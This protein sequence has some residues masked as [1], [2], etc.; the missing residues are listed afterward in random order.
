MSKW[1]RYLEFFR[2]N[3]ARDIDDEISSHLEM[4]IADLRARGLTEAAARSQALSEFGDREAA[5]RDALRVDQRMMRREARGE[6]LDGLLRD[7]RVAVRSLRANPGFAVSAILCAAAGIGITAA[8]VSA[9]YA[10]LVRSLPYRDSD[11]V[12]A[13]YAENVTRG[14]THTNISSPDFASWR[15]DNR[16]FSGIAIW[17]WGTKTLGAGAGSDAERLSGADVSWNLFRILGVAP[18]LGRDFLQEEDAPGRQFEVLISHQLWQR[19]F[20]SDSAIVGQ[21]IPI[22]GRAWTVVGVMPRGFNFP[23]VGDYW[24]PFAASPAER[25]GDRGY[26]G[27]IGRLAPGV[28]LA[29]AAADLHR[30]DAE[31]A[32]RFPDD[33]REWRAQLIPI[34][35]DLI[36]DLRAPLRVLLA[37]VGLVLLLACINIAGL[38]LA[39]GAAR[40]REIAIRTAVGA[41][42]ERLVRQLLTESVVIAGVGGIL[43]LGI[44]AAAM[45][46]LT[47][48]FPRGVPFYIHLE[49]DLSAVTFVCVITLLTGLLFGIVPALRGSRIELTAAL[50]DG[51]SGS[52]IGVDRAR[53][54]RGL[55]VAE[56]ALSAV[57]LTGAF[58]LL[59][60]YRNLHGMPLGY[61]P[62]GVVTAR[63]TLPKNAGYPT[64][65]DVK[66]FYDRLFER[67]RGDPRVAVVG[68]AQGTPMTGWDVQGSLDVDGG[69]PARAGDVLIVHYQYVTADYFRAIGV[70]LVRGRWLDATDRDSLHPSVLVNER[71]VAKAFNGAEPI[72]KRVR[73]GS[74][75]PWGTVVGVIGDFQQF[76]IP[77][78]IPPAVYWSDAS[79]PVRQKTVAIR[80]RTG[81]PR[82]LVPAL[83]SAVREIDPGVAVYQIQTMNEVLDRTL[84]R[85]SFMRKVLI[86]F[87]T[88]A[89]SMACLGLYGVLSYTVA[90]RTRE[91]GVR[92]ALGASRVRLLRMVL[93]DGARLALTGIAAGLVT[94]WFAARF[95]AA[96]LYGVEANDPMVFAG[97]AGALIAVALLAMMIPSRR[98]TRVDPLVAMRAE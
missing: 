90:Q 87:A 88:L 45:R 1:L 89:I 77:E 71:L 10:I 79:Y 58:L 7:A 48:A 17:G 78:A 72:G 67:L 12:V 39:R 91:F 30:V 3:P 56:V 76:R 16:T 40:S 97:V 23:D 22:D 50:R 42:R 82:D 98:A 60:T 73:I 13:I 52:G 74:E 81:D 41:S 83:R 70:R 31:L 8:T 59:A 15:D 62:N 26:A 47:T 46:V 43:G 35:E 36:G 51:T 6:A 34:R 2:K 66:R 68:F 96:V 65:P 19:R 54:R 37:A 27:A 20:G 11:R 94:A 75:G 93:G 61:V 29:Q 57:L 64:Q 32:S 33:N 84:W 55:V 25:H 38:T 49:L 86:A 24:V 95:L 69:S 44:A 80:A 28:T 14:F 92:V 9:G 63:I 18:V 21:T 53:L 5:R 85:Q 4:R